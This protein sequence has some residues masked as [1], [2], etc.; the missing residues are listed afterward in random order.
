MGEPIVGTGDG[1]VSWGFGR[2][3]WRLKSRLQYPGL[4]AGVEGKEHRHK[5]HRQEYTERQ[6]HLVGRDAEHTLVTREEVERGR[7]GVRD[8]VTII[9]ILVQHLIHILML[10]AK[11]PE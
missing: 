7:R 5:K 6:Y 2:A 10:L 11:S 4:D 9:I 1:G 8:I 3:V